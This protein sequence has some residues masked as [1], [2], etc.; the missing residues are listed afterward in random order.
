MLPSLHFFVLHKNKG[1]T[2]QCIHMFSQQLLPN[3]AS[4]A[5]CMWIDTRSVDGVNIVR[6]VL[7]CGVL[8]VAN[9]LYHSIAHYISP[10]RHAHKMIPEM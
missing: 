3:A 5:T 6:S 8:E 1:S 7:E 2:A 9:R 10:K 4:L